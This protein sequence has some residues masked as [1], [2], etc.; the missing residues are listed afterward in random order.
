MGK[1]TLEE[2]GKILLVSFISILISVQATRRVLL[3]SKLDKTEFNE[4]KR[5]HEK[6]HD[7]QHEDVIYIRDKLDKL[8]EHELNKKD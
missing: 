2:V 6:K 3:D 8:Y 7:R 1:K 4:Y 5:D